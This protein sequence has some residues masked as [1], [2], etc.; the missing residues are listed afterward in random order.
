MSTEVLT[1][2][3]TAPAT[4]TPPP[5]PKEPTPEQ[6]AR[7]QAFLDR[8]TG[9]T[10]A[11][12]QKTMEGVKEFEGSHIE[13]ATRM[14]KT[15]EQQEADTKAAEEA[16]KKTE[17]EAA[18]KAAE[19]KPPEAKEPE[20]KEPEPKK[21]TRR[22]QQQDDDRIAQV[23]ADAA[24]RAV[25]ATQPKAPEPKQEPA[26]E[27][28]LGA[29]EQDQFV[30]LQE[31]ERINPEKKG[32]AKAYAD[33]IKARE[34][35]ERDWKKANP[36][37]KF[38][39]GD[40]EHNAF[41]EEQE[42]KL[43]YNDADL[44]KAERAMLKRELQQEQSQHETELQ[45]K[46]RA[47]EEKE[48]IDTTVQDAEKRVLGLL[49]IEDLEKADEV[50]RPVLKRAVDHAKAFSKTAYSLINGLATEDPQNRLHQEVGQITQ[51]LMQQLA[52][53]PAEETLNDQGQQYVDPATY[54]HLTPQQQQRVWTL[55]ATDVI[56][57]QNNE[58]SKGVKAYLKQEE[59]K[60]NARAEKRGL[61]LEK[62]AAKAPE[63]RSNST[64]TPAP[65]ARKSTM[66][67]LGSEV[68]TTAPKT[69][70]GEP[71]KKGAALWSQSMGL[72]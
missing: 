40:Q 58:I 48:N 38:D 12:A 55:T 70:N 25:Q 28:S 42:A 5:A 46:V 29:E 27:A 32:V 16:A 1:P 6:V 57:F 18:A 47:L 35:Y 20:T 23:A 61:K 39:D 62:P 66:P 67:S 45:R 24:A 21:R 2:P 30:V 7:K 15:K 8:I 64:P 54:G 10:A 59:E 11:E 19:P 22:T 26:P 68:I 17:T 52:A 53:M 69:N 72:R 34:Q 14:P 71:V 31:L 3:A 60:F 41:F 44:K 43:N 65:S 4:A 33:G 9:K 49:E 37:Q 13:R 36:G 51:R 63:T 56:E 50:D